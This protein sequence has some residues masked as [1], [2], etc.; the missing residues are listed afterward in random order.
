VRPGVE[1]DRFD[2]T[3]LA[4]LQEDASATNGVL[5][6]RIGLSA[7]QVSRRRQAL[8]EAG[9]IRGYRALVDREALGLGIVVMVHVTMA[10]H[11]PENAGRF[12][13][14]ALARPEVLDAFTLTGEADYVLKVVVADLKAL[15]AFIN[16]VLLPHEAVDRVRSEVVL[17][18]IKENGALPI[19]G[20]EGRR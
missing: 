3:L 19:P 17:E 5:A 20:G 18:A 13:R 12:R 14:L 11:S 10:R 9:V 16:D 8:E 1:L 6:E 2:H 15:A 4:A 7:S